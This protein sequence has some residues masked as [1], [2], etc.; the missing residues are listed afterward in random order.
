MEFVSYNELNPYKCLNIRLKSKNQT[1]M[2]SVKSFE[3]QVQVE[4]FNIL[5]KMWNNIELKDQALV[6]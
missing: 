2:Q 1:L 3:S 5:L 6:T 4:N